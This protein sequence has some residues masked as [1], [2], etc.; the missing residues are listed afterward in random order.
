MSEVFP[1]SPRKQDLKGYD[2]GR[3]EKG[4]DFPFFLWFEDRE[5][6][7]REEFRPYQEHLPRLSAGH[8]AGQ[9]WNEPHAD[10]TYPYM[11]NGVHPIVRAPPFA[12]VHSNER[13]GDEDLL[14]AEEPQP[15]R[16]IRTDGAEAGIPRWVIYGQRGGVLLPIHR[17]FVVLEGCSP[18]NGVQVSGHSLPSR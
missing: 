10:E 6:A 4:S 11:V 3:Y 9:H 13:V 1:Q 18:L 7:S 15:R 14:D 12:G 17:A 5:V 16:R 2:A 8:L